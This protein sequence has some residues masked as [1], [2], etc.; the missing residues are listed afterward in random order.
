MLHRAPRGQV[1]V[2]LIA[3]VQKSGGLTLQDA[4][5]Q[6]LSQVP[7]FLAY[8][9]RRRQRRQ[10]R[11]RQAAGHMG[12]VLSHLGFVAQ[13]CTGRMRRIFVAFVVAVPLLKTR[14]PDSGP[15]SDAPSLLPRRG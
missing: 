2:K 7:T 8:P 13:L 1:L 6:A 4:T 3:D 14:N 12:D 10:K 11:R 9:R 15:D 5:R